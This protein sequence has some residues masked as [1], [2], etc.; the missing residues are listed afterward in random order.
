MRSFKHIILGLLLFYV[1]HNLLRIDLVNKSIFPFLE[2]VT[3][4]S[5]NMESVGV[6]NVAW[7]IMITS[8]YT[9]ILVLSMV[10]SSKIKF[11]DIGNKLISYLC[12]FFWFKQLFF[13]LYNGNKDITYDIIDLIIVLGVIA[14]FFV[15]G[16]RWREKKSGIDVIEDDNVFY[17]ISENPKYFIPFIYSLVT[18]RDKPHKKIVY[19]GF[20][21]VYN[22]RWKFVCRAYRNTG[23]W[24]EQFNCDR[25]VIN[26]LNHHVGKNGSYFDPCENIIQEILLKYEPLKSELD[27]NTKLKYL[28]KK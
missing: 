13:F 14:L 25:K 2:N 7:F 16:K 28:Y 22:W 6:N 11:A 1:S 17:V 23:G 15:K 9:I 19:N 26:L 21:Y 10:V 12:V 4:N 27:A 3:K 5:F 24:I 18:G 8:F 20:E